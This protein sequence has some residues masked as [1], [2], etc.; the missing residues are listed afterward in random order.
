ME[1]RH[2]YFFNSKDP[3]RTAL[4]VSIFNARKLSGVFTPG[5]ILAVPCMQ[6]T[7]HCSCECEGQRRGEFRLYS[8]MCARG[9]VTAGP[10]GED[11]PPVFI[12]RA[13]AKVGLI[14]QHSRNSKASLSVVMEQVNLQP[15]PPVK[16]A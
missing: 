12:D 3:K 10:S 14:E 4:A 16:V 15:N 8:K 5:E 9:V 1:Y 11:V 6:V 2:P 7:M 13:G